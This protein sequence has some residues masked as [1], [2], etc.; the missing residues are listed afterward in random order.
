MSRFPFLSAILLCTVSALPAYGANNAVY[1]SQNVPATMTA[2]EVRSVTVTMRNSGTTTWTAAGNYRLGSQ[3][4]E[5]NVTWGLNRAAPATGDAIAPNQQKTF[6]FTITAP[7]VAGTYNFQWRMLVEN[8]EWFGAFTPNVAIQVT[9]PVANAAQF[10]SQSVPASLSTGEAR[11]VSVTMKN[12]GTATWTAAAGYKLGSQNPE[13]NAI[14]RFGRVD[15]APSDAIAPGQ[16][17]TFT[18]GITA[19]AT[20]GTYNFQWRMLREN[21]QW[22]GDFTPNVAIQVAQVVTLCSGV[23]VPLD[24][25]T[26][27]APKIQQCINARPS[28]GTLELPAGTYTIASQIVIGKPFTLRTAGTAGVNANCEAAGVGCAVLKARADLFVFGGLIDVQNTSNVTLD[29]LVIDGNRAARQGSAAD[30]QCIPDATHSNRYGYNLRFAGCT[31]CTF[32]HSVSR[33]TLCGSALEWVGADA[34]ITDNVFRANGQNSLPGRWSDG[35]TL[36][37]GDGADVLNNLFV[38]NSDIALILGGGR[39]AMVMNNAIRQVTQLAFGGLMLDNFNGTSSGDFTGAIVTGNSIDCGAS[40]LCDLGINLGPHAW[41]LSANIQGGSVFNNTVIN[42]RQGINVD[43]A[44][45]VANPLV[46]YSNAV[47]GSPASAVVSCNPNPRPTSN[48]NIYAPD[49]VVNRNGDTTPATNRQWH[50][51]P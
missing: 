45:T 7:S 11:Q 37:A 12:T 49:S 41:Y 2:G 28:G 8:V 44:G 5:N 21:V 23:Q 39:N 22:F 15:L 25:T 26:D 27:A 6:S 50:E 35:L 24:G 43:G 40:R 9:A 32:K 16:Q 19:P 4:P 33:N 42:A 18:F 36:L 30:T 20:A 47:S 1:V 34:T 38:D 3:N 51:C 17:K 10:V 31:S 29:H 48:L 13:N 14:W 46:L